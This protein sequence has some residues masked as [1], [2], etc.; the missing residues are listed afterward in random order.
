MNVL[1]NRISSTL[2]GEWLALAEAGARSAGKFLAGSRSRVEVVANFG[3]DIKL[4]HDRESEERIVRLLREHSDL[5]ILSEEQGLIPGHATDQEM[6]W[7]VDPL[8]GSLNYLRGIPFCCVSVGLWKGEAPVLGAIYDFDREE[9]FT[10]IAEGG[11]WLNG[12]AI[13]VSQT[14]NSSDAVLCT[15]FPVGMDL[16]SAPLLAFVEQV[17][18]YKKV[19]LFGSAALSLAYV[20]AGRVDAYCER[21]IRLWDVAAGLA[22]VRG[23]GGHVAQRMSGTAHAL[24]VHAGNALLDEDAQ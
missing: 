18:R 3:K 23:A 11:A 19:R 21:D 15:G 17:R 4:S 1:S 22:I 16:A 13:T 12:T 5:P 8:D 2:L 24:T 14:K 10:G 20:A 7:I 9:L 6:R